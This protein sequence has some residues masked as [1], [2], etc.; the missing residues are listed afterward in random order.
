MTEVWDHS[1]PVQHWRHL[2][3]AQRSLRLRGQRL[4]Y[5][6]DPQDSAPAHIIDLYGA[7][8]SD[9]DRLS[10]LLRP[11][12]GQAEVLKLRV[13][14]EVEKKMWHERLENAIRNASPGLEGEGPQSGTMS[15]RGKMGTYI[16][17]ISGAGSVRKS[18]SDDLS[19]RKSSITSLDDR[20]A[21]Q[22]K[23][24]TSV[25]SG[26]GNKGKPKDRSNSISSAELQPPK[27]KEEDR[28]SSH[29]SSS[30]SITA[31]S[32]SAV[33]SAFGAQPSFIQESELVGWKK[34]AELGRGSFGQ[35]WLGLLTNGKF[36][37]VKQIEFGIA[38]EDEAIAAEIQTELNLMHKLSH[39]NIVRCYGAK[40]VDRCLSIFLEYVPQGA[41]SKVIKMFGP[42]QYVTALAYTQQIVAGLVYLHSNNVIHRDI[43]CDNVLLD[44][45]GLV[46]LSDFGCAKELARNCETTS[47]VVGTPNF[48]AP[49]VIVH[50]KYDAKADVWSLGCTCVE[51]ITGLPPW[52]QF[53]TVWA[54]LNHI[55]ESEGPPGLPPDLDQR[56]H[57]FLLKCFERDPAKRPSSFEL[58]RLPIIQGSDSVVTAP[59]ISR[60][61]QA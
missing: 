26:N 45:N 13:A 52:P 31:P 56:F 59:T 61:P 32:T 36:V 22:K 8:I 10:L 4:Y 29:N 46:K 37:A 33:G 57:R 39:P 30:N 43:K 41:L 60:T 44:N 1:G 2:H 51:M 21:S 28:N 58:Q 42:L 3:W 20:S 34:G 7:Q 19:V 25:P 53:S 23:S 5:F 11:K 17:A 16:R 49:E 14:T 54:A 55:A 12:E 27:V 18:T 24:P 9:L 35:V 47:T 40:L 50:G 38:A 15:A 48:I 6:K